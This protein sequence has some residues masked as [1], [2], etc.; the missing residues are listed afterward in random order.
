MTLWQLGATALYHGIPGY[1]DSDVL[2]EQINA[3]TEPWT[4]RHHELFVCLEHNARLGVLFATLLLA[5]NRL[6]TTGTLAASH[7]SM[8]EDMLGGWTSK[9]RV[10]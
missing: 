3:L 8:L 9:D 2:L 4:P 7:H 1:F 6:E 10:V 5:M